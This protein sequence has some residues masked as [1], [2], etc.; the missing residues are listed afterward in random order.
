MSFSRPTAFSRIIFSGNIL[1]IN[2]SRLLPCLM[3]FCLLVLVTIA[4]CAQSLEKA[5]APC[6][7]RGKGETVTVRQVIDGDTLVLKDGRSVRL[8]GVNTPEM[9]R[10]KRSAQPLA[11]QARRFLVDILPA[12][13]VVLLR[14]GVQP[15]DHYGRTLAHLYLPDGRSIEA[16]ILSAGLGFQIVIPPNTE[17]LDCLRLAERGAQRT[18]LGIWR[19]PFFRAGDVKEISAAHQ[20]FSR[21]KGVLKQVSISAGTWWL[22]L[23]GDLVLYIKPADQTY[24]DIKALHDLRGQTITVR[25]WMVYRGEQGA[26]KGKA[27]KTWIMALKHPNAIEH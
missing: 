5:P 9:A 11:K 26:V 21:V 17:H 19:E 2:R 13:K 18:Q 23:E 22:D 12:D 3:R 8:I 7:W 25:G 16:L 6:E 10:K 14:P 20:G 1:Q 24:F 15:K 27:Y 4:S